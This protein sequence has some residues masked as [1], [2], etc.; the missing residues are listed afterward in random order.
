M[1]RINRIIN[2]VIILHFNIDMYNRYLYLFESLYN[3]Q[4]LFNNIII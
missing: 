2:Y 4:R 3:F 1:N